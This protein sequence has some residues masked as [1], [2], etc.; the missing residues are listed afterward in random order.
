M[1]PTLRDHECERTEVPRATFKFDELSA[2][3]ILPDQVSRHVS[4]AQTG[5]EKIPLGAEI[6]DQPQAL[7]GNSLLGLF[8]P[9]LI[10]RDDDLDMTSK[11]VHR[12]GFR[13]R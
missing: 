13:C 8:R 6:I 10:V 1:T 7:A 12:Y 5:F 2:R 11:L 4:P 3:Q 9:R